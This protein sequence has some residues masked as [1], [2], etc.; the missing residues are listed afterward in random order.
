MK[1]KSLIVANIIILVFIVIALITIMIVGQVRDWDFTFENKTE[2]VMDQKFDENILNIDVRDYDILIKENNEDNI[3]IVIETSSKNSDDIKIAEENEKITITQKASHVC[4]GFCYFSN[5]ITI[6]IGK[7]YDKSLNLYSTSGDIKVLR[8]LNG[9]DHVIKTTSGDIEITS[10]KK[11]NISSTSGEIKIEEGES[12]NAKTTSGDIEINSLKEKAKLK[13]TSGEIEVKELIG[14]IEAEATSGDIEI[15]SFTII[16]DSSIATKSGEIDIRLINDASIT[17]STTSGDKK[18]K[19]SMGE[20]TLD[21][22]AT[23]GDI[24]VR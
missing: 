8:K 23:S 19:N 16:G 12:I 21:L 11:S 3:R 13:S 15:K 2:I 1:N 9:E 7:N 22:R 17:A 10:I 6:Y 5:R 24:R 14:S 20:Y 18:I 4:F